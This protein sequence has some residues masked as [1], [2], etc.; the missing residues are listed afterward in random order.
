MKGYRNS[1]LLL[2]SLII[3]SDSSHATLQCPEI[4]NS[5]RLS[6]TGNNYTVT[7]GGQS[8]KTETNAGYRVYWVGT[9]TFQQSHAPQITGIGEPIYS[10]AKPDFS[11]SYVVTEPTGSGIPVMIRPYYI[12]I[13]K[14]SLEEVEGWVKKYA[15]GDRNITYDNKNWSINFTNF[16]SLPSKTLKE[17]LPLRAGTNNNVVQ[18]PNGNINLTAQFLLSVT[19]GLEKYRIILTSPMTINDF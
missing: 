18:T 9:K 8:V 5:V 12:S 11:C 14:P 10:Q 6:H 7:V 2:F 4:G 16:D 15:S 1:S 13:P 3:L 19:E 17:I